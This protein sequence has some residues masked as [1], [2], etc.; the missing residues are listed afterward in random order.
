MVAR[1]RRLSRKRERASPEGKK[2]MD[3]N[4]ARNSG[5]KERRG[6]G[7]HTYCFFCEGERGLPILAEK[8]GSS[9]MYRRTSDRCHKG[10]R[11]RKRYPD[12]GRSRSLIWQQGGKREGEKCR[13]SSVEG[14]KK[15]QT[16]FRLCSKKVSE[17]RLLPRKTLGIVDG[18]NNHPAIL[19][20]RERKRGEKEDLVLR[21]PLTREKRERASRSITLICGKGRGERR[22]EELLDWERKKE[23]SPPSQR[24]MH[25]F[26]GPNREGRKKKKRVLWAEGGHFAILDGK[27]K[28]KEG[29]D[30][31]PQKI[32]V[33]G[34]KEGKTAQGR[35]PRSGKFFSGR[36]KVRNKGKMFP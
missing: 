13:L 14:G 36:G 19:I 2:G 11:G 31:Y 7:V 29:K 8:G 6:R 4:Y 22:S 20:M 12:L 18:I 5:G 10:E 15:K 34:K 3:C 21:N 30:N 28:G 9:C 1:R 16:N 23:V 25:Q 33:K 35:L 27:K 17:R 24:G 32:P 26:A